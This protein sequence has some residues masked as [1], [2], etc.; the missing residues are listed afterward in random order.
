MK[1]ISRQLL[2]FFWIKELLITVSFFFYKFSSWL[3]K[4][5]WVAKINLHHIWVF[6]DFL[7]LIFSFRSHVWTKYKSSYTLNALFRNRRINIKLMTIKLVHQLR[8][9]NKITEFCI[10][11]FMTTSVILS[12]A[13]VLGSNLFLI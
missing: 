6:Y 9:K 11:S 8:S 10:L 7:Q 4:C 3:G 5:L 1:V 12:L 13:L 2:L